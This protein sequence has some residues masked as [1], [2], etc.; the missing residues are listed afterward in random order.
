MLRL[1]RAFVVLAF[2]A[3]PVLAAPPSVPDWPFDVLKLKNG[4]TH[5]GMLLEETSTD[6]RFMVV[7]RAPGRPTVRVTFKFTKNEVAKLDKLSEED[8][9]SLRAKL[10]EIDP[11]SEARKLET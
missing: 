6:V 4:V 7:G 3:A 1:S 8:R 2:V 9:E 11:N 10:D 5:K